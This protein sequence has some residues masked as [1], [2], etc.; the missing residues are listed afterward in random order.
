MTIPDFHNAERLPPL[1]LSAPDPQAIAEAAVAFA[2][3]DGGLITFPGQTAPSCEALQTALLDAGA[4]TRPALFLGCPKS[5]PSTQGG[6]WALYVPRGTQVYALADGRVLVRTLDGVRELDGE[7][8]RRLAH[9]RE[10]G[11]FEAELVPGAAVVNLDEALLAE[12]ARGAVPHWDGDA[13]ALWERVGA[14]TPKGDVTVAGMLLFGRDPQRWLPAAHVQ[15]EHVVAGQAILAEAVGGPLPRQMSA[16]WEVL[17]LHARLAG[18]RPPYA[19]TLLREIVFNALVHRDYRLRRRPVRVRLSRSDLVVESPGGL[20]GYLANVS[21]MLEGRYLRN[22]RLY[23]ILTHWG[24]CSE[25]GAHAVSAHADL[26]GYP[27]VRWEVEPYAVRVHIER[28]VP[29]VRTMASMTVVS[30]SEQQQR[31]LRLARQRG[32]ITLRELQARWGD[33]VHPASLQRDLDTLVA[34]GYLRRFGG[35]SAV[36]YVR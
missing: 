27:T 25:R 26:D 30:L 5:L 29:E 17:S 28:C 15:F 1:Q 16:L 13:V 20:S 11:D 34:A 31:I 12:F 7:A 4:L 23:T 21:D 2:N 3:S 8:I 35:R 24:I 36:Y 32:S 18:P 10:Q 33:D 6:G 22:P 19:P 9:A 14:L